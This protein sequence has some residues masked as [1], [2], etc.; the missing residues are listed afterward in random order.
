MKLVRF[1]RDGEIRIGAHIG[2]AHYLDLAEAA[3]I[4]RDPVESAVGDMQTLIEG[5]LVALEAVTGLIDAAPDEAVIAQSSVQLLTPL[6]NPRKIRD[7]STFE[8]HLRQAAEGA[9]R[10]LASTSDNPAEAYEQLLV[11]HGLDQIPPAGWR[12][13]PGYYYV[14]VGPVSGPDEPVVWPRYSQW[15]DYELELAVVIGRQGKDIPC[16]AALDHVFGYTIFNDL[17]ARDAQLAAMATGLG[18]AK[19][20]DFDGSTVLGPCIVTADE[21]SD[22]HDLTMIARVNGEEVGRGHSGEAFWSIADCIAY[23]SQ[24]QTIRSGEVFATGTVGNGS[25]IETGLVLECGNIVELEIESI[26]V[27]RTPIVQGSVVS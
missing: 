5:G 20:K 25:T 23:A 1:R 2:E 24:S 26:G 8:K 7:F 9:A 16:D 15:I 4:R 21:I 3:R 18:P 13:L 17:S 27:L 22:P 12:S 19:G 10:R 6:P 11:A 14:D